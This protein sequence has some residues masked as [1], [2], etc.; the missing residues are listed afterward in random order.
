MRPIFLFFPWYSG[1]TRALIM[2]GECS[3]TEYLPNIGLYFTFHLL[4]D[5]VPL[6]Y[7]GQPWTHDSPALASQ[8]AEVSSMYPS[9]HLLSLSCTTDFKL[10]HGHTINIMAE[11][12]VSILSMCT[13]NLSNLT[14][15]SV[16]PSTLY[17]VICDH[18]CPKTLP[19][20]LSFIK[21]FTHRKCLHRNQSHCTR[22]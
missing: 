8:I 13:I 5:R 17:E 19:I 18:S 9:A 12:H 11:N 14:G 20:T 21:D 15:P 3:T 7:P 22:L 1:W 6:S 10:C 4:W 16:T 2:I